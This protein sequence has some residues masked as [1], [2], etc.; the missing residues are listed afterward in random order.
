MHG[1]PP[2]FKARP[3]PNPRNGRRL[4]L[5]NLDESLAHVICC[6]DVAAF[7][8]CSVLWSAIF[9]ATRRSTPALMRLRAALRRKSWGARPVYTLVLG[10]YFPRPEFAAGRIP[11]LSEVPRIE[12]TI[13]WFR[14]RFAQL[15]KGGRNFF[16]W[17]RKRYRQRLL[18]PSRKVLNSGRSRNPF[19]GF[20][21]AGSTN[22]G[23]WLSV[24]P[25]W[26]FVIKRGLCS[27]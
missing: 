11:D 2:R 1:R 19:R 18:V 12:N 9:I 23:M 27:R 6:L 3:L 22:V 20:E 8:M 14:E 25:V 4:E 24:S 21:S 15:A 5:A 7:E 16:Q 13:S 17:T 26:R 10:S